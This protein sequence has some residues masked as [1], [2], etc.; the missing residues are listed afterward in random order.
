ML[1]LLLLL[2]QEDESLD[3]F[4][5]NLNYQLF[6]ASVNFSSFLNKFTWNFR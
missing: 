5:F 6:T 1:E 2:C 3:L 4:D